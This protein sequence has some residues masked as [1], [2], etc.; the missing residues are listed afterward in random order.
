MSIE[1]FSSICKISF[2]TFSSENKS[3]PSRSCF[4]K[5]S[6]LRHLFYKPSLSS[7]FNFLKLN[8]KPK[9]FSYI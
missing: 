2:K 5:P 7:D 3:K 1:A 4:R 9:I 8:K 6:R